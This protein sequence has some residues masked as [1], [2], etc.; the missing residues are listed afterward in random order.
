MAV[1][2]YRLLATAFSLARFTT[3]ELAQAARTN[4][5]TAASWLRRNKSLIE[6][7]VERTKQDHAGRR[8]VV[9]CLRPGSAPAIRA[10]LDQLYPHV[11]RE[12]N[13]NLR[14]TG[15]L[16]SLEKAEIHIE[17]WRSAERRA[18]QNPHAEDLESVARR[19][20]TSAQN[21]IRHTWQRFAELDCAEIKIADEHLK[22]LA[23]LEREI[24][25]GDLPHTKALPDFAK[26]LLLRLQ[27]MSQ[28]GATGDF[29]IKVMEIRATLRPNVNHA[30]LTAA[31]LAAPIWWQEGLA[32]ETTLDES[33]IGL[34][35]RFARRHRA[36]E[37]TAAIALV[38]TEIG[39]SSLPEPEQRQAL[40]LGL[41]RH[42]EERDNSFRKETVHQ[43]L[44][45][46]RY[47]KGWGDE[48][49]LP[50]VRG[51]VLGAS[52]KL[53][54]LAADLE[55]ALSRSLQTQWSA[56][57]WTRSWKAGP[58]R[59]DTR[60]FGK[61]F[62]DDY[63]KRRNI[64]QRLEEIANRKSIGSPALLEDLLTTVQQDIR[65]RTDQG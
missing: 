42:T 63:P 37:M 51:L 44:A 58:T 14:D 54:A 26:W 13:G 10:T 49:A 55:P 41:V 50:V 27:T 52:S 59:S 35:D 15:D 24:G 31:V 65:S 17:R 38:L 12:T 45:Y 47:M 64:V 62:L 1:E 30:M 21:W 9:W 16:Q 25:G 56:V 3:D 23:E 33:S 19:E 29:A 11:M 2:K 28:Q 7:E 43:F 46:L 48:L 4:R 22:N 5:N 32:A 36:E 60:E 6:P 20:K 40:V 18:R 57:C 39:E 34:C 53:E 8:P 61:R